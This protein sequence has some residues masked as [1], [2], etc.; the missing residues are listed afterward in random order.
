M[1]PGEQ[2]MMYAMLLWVLFLKSG[3]EMHLNGIVIH[4]MRDS[5][6]IR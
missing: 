4:T 3:Q 2:P 5:L 1:S 6:D